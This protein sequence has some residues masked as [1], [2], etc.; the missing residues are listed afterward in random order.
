[1]KTLFIALAVV[2]S[3]L[4]GGGWVMTDEKSGEV[5]GFSEVGSVDCTEL[6]EGLMEIMGLRTEVEGLRTMDDGQ[7]LGIAR[8][9]SAEETNIAEEK[10]RRVM[11]EG[12][13]VVAPLLGL[14]WGQGT[15]YNSKCPE[16]ASGQGGHAQVGCGALVMGQI[17]RYWRYPT[18]GKGSHSYV[19]N[20]GAYGYGNYGTQSADFENTT[21][22]YDH[23]PKQ[24]KATSSDEE[25]EAVGTLLYH[26]GVS[27]DMAYG[28]TASTAQSGKMVTALSKYFRF[29]AT[30][31]YIEKSQY[32]TSEWHNILQG[33]LDESAPFFYG[34]SGSYGGHVFICDGYRDDDFYHLVWGWGGQYDGWFKIGDFTPGPY[35]FNNNHAAIIGIRGPEVPTNLDENEDENWV[36][37]CENPVKEVLKLNGEHSGEIYD[38]T[39]RCVMNFD[40]STIDVHGLMEGAYVV[41]VE[42]GEC[43][44]ILIEK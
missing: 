42:K 29:P 22:D 32:S 12:N 30:I 40:G 39:G 37:V 14:K 18:N 16:D 9:G 13:E 3:N 21:Y 43:A 26:C 33:E 41:R 28:P 31:E 11:A 10:I 44:L 1:M 27:V 6:P 35:D 38:M 34:A 23:M 8:L 4:A 20:F 7:R 24:L 36:L 2:F 25:I 19:A 5:L 15:R 17:M